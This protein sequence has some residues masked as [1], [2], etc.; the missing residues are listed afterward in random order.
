MHNR[1]FRSG[2]TLLEILVVVMIITILASIVSVNVLRRPGEARVSAAR[3]Q[4]KQLKTA[5]ELYRTEQGRLPTQQQGLAALVAKP[6]IDPI[7]QSYP[8][9]GYLDTRKM[10]LDPWKNEFI[11]LTPGREGELFEI[12]TYG[13]D[14]EPGGGEEGSDI[15][16]SDL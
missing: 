6:V 5:V 2:F 1:D 11:Y 13:A 10:P 3:M 12:I 7:P 8:E 15:S 9:D 4:L 16:T 14:N